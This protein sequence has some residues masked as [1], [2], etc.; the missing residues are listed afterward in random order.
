MKIKTKVY[1]GGSGT[2]RCDG[3]GGTPSNPIPPGSLQ[4]P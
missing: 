3:G 4:Q 2:T 1:A